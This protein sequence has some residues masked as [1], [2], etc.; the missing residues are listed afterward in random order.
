MHGVPVFTWDDAIAA[1]AQAWADNGVYEH[2]TN[3]ARVINSEQCGENLAWGYPT[4]DGISS[5]VAWYS[6]IQ[7]TEP[8]G[9]A[10]SM[11]DAVPANEAIGHYTQVV[12]KGSTK[13]G[14]GKGTATVGGNAGDYWVCQYCTAGNYGGQFTQNVL[15]P[16]KTAA[17]CGGQASDVPSGSGGSGATGNA[18][19]EEASLPSTCTPSKSLSPGGLCV[20]GWQCAS[21]FCCPRLKVCLADSGSSVSATD[22]NVDDSVRQDVIDTVFGGGSCEDPWADRQACMQTNEGQPLSSWNQTKCQCKDFYMDKY[23]SCSWV[24]LNKD[25]ACQCGT[26]APAPGVASASRGLHPDA[27]PL[28]W[29]LAFGAAAALM[30]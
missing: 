14:C 19:E 6:E 3:A 1:N 13:L 17:E 11:T 22:I 28:L 10:D 21:K 24:S 5:T 7:Y 26:P 12:W 25:V 9:T 15:A 16:T 2:S 18:A 23:K 8:Y 30:A 27:L 20:Y 29:A 4:R